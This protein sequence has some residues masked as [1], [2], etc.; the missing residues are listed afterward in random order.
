V[1]D[2]KIGSNAKRVALVGL[3]IALAFVFSWLEFIFPLQIPIPGVKLGI[4]NLV[5][6]FAL[7]KLKLPDVIAVSLFRIVLAGFL[8]GGLS[9]MIYALCGGV[10]SLAVMIALKATSKFSP[11]A[12]SVAGGVSH[13]L[14]QLA[15]ALFA[16][17][18]SAVLAYA[19]ALVAGGIASGALVGA[20]GALVVGKIRL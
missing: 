11:L 19:P 12:V 7:Y 1:S 3:F 20:L 16:M 18:T 15:F 5:S 8:F 10:L 9:S 17:N 4:A 14:G 6:L 13:N 2:K